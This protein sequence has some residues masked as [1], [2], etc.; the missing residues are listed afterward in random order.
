MNL[1]EFQTGRDQFDRKYPLKIV[2]T[3]N[4]TVYGHIVKY[5][6]Y[7]DKATGI[8][9]ALIENI[10]DWSKNINEENRK[11]IYFDDDVIHQISFLKNY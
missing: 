3:D 1:T 6:Q 9:F 8:I 10:D 4:T 2:F 7:G 11:R 5:E